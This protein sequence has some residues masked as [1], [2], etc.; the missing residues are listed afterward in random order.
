M[1]FKVVVHR[2]SVLFPTIGNYLVDS[3]S[4][5]IASGF[6]LSRAEKDYPEEK[7]HVVSCAVVDG[8]FIGKATQPRAQLTSG[9]RGKNKGRVSIAT[10]N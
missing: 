8:D 7:L 10:R 1:I 9:G 6:A 3:S 2:D 5:E 4:G